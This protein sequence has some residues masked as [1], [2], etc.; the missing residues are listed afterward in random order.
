MAQSI[1]FGTTFATYTNAQIIGTG[2][3][4][5]VY[6]TND[7]D[8]QPWAVKVLDPIKVSRDKLKRFQNEYAFCS[9]HSHPHIVTVADHGIVLVDGVKSPFLVMPLFDGSLRK[10]MDEGIPTP[11][12]LPLFSQILDGVEAAH[13]LKVVHRERRHYKTMA[14]TPLIFSSW[15]LWRCG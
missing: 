12:V 14:H 1:R 5:R 4:A 15:L 3:S 7:Q 10:V 9:E 6:R 8:G 11:K 13:L 2:G